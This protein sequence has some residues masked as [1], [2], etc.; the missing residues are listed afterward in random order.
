M[1]GDILD[2]RPVRRKFTARNEFTPWPSSVLFTVCRV[3]PAQGPPV[4]R[5]W[6]VRGL[7]IVRND[8]VIN[9][10]VNGVVFIGDSSQAMNTFS[11]TSP[12]TIKVHDAIISF[13]GTPYSI[14]FKKFTYTIEHGD[15]LYVAL[16]GTATSGMVECNARVDEYELEFAS[17]MRI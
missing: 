14:G 5:L 12:D 1:R 4:N 3:T 17:A 6:D 10:V 16:F 11:S 8:L 13:T 9:P 2:K 15:C 7:V